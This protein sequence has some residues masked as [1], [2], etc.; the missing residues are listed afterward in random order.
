MLLDGRG[1]NRLAADFTGI[2]PGIVR[3]QLKREDR[4]GPANWVA[5][6]FVSVVVQTPQSLSQDAIH[7]RKETSQALRR[8]DEVTYRPPAGAPSVFFAPAP[9]GD[10]AQSFLVGASFLVKWTVRL[11]GLRRRSQDEF[12]RPDR[13][14]R[15][16]ALPRLDGQL[17]AA[18]TPATGLYATAQIGY[19]PNSGTR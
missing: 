16:T 3:G 2:S 13:C 11:S 1:R 7:N 19:L 18:A 5:G 14:G 8:G 15:T 6:R 4:I 17:L 10:S 9:R 12:T